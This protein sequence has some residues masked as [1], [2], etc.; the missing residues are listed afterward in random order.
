MIYFD[1]QTISIIICLGGFM[2]T[3]EIKELIAILETS[4]L[5]ELSYKEEGFEISLKK[6]GDVMRQAP[7]Q[8]TNLTSTETNLLNKN[9]IQS[10]LVG[11][12]Y[13][14]PSPDETSFLKV[15]DSIKVGDVVCIIE[16]M[17]VMNEIKSDQAG[18]VKELLVQD[19]DAVGFNQDILVLE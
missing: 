5:N 2:K 18:V 6:A 17:K 9:T 1:N 3:K 11:V 15:G 10:P 19:G 14:K 12:Y 16:A 8:N 13:D 4:Q 7:T